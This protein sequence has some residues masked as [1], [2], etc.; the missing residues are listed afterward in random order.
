ML[1]KGS[2]PWMVAAVLFTGATA[3]A[4]YITNINGLHQIAYAGILGTTFFTWFFRDPKRRTKICNRC[5][6]SPADGKVIDIRGRKVCIFMNVH[7]VHVNRAPMSGKILKVEHKNGGYI[8]AFH[9]DSERNERTHI[10]IDT[11]Y[12]EVEIT[13][14]AGVL[15]R[16]IVT[17]VNE[18]DMIEQGKRIGMIRFGSRVDV[19]VPDTHEITCKKGDKVYAGETVIAKF[20]S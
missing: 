14:I 11:E 9:K 6:V 7:N 17:Y 18:G 20:K 16:R 2:M 1:A 19:T 8:P 3:A 15:V 10:T 5:M 12:G 4:S 13:Q